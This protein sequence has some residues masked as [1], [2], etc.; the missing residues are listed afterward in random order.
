[1]VSPNDIP[2]VGFFLFELSNCHQT[3]RVL[4][5]TLCVGTQCQKFIHLTCNNVLPIAPK[6]IACLEKQMVLSTTTERDL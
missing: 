4:T 6:E 5:F 1:M 2:A 3:L